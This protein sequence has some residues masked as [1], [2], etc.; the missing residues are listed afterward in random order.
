[1]NIDDQLSSN[2]FD[3]TQGPQKKLSDYLGQWIVLYFYP[4]D[5]TPGCTL[6]SQAFRD[7]HAEFL[8][9]NAVV[10]GVSR[11]SLTS[12]EKFKTKECLPFELIADTDEQLC[13]QFDVIKMKSM[14]GKSVRGIERST[15]LIDPEGI[16]RHEWRKVKVD[17]HVKEVLDTLHSLS[18]K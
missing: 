4:K 6:E 7:H 16:L 12:H 10:L 18:T 11:D 1:M 5:A 8:A 3:T 17:G 9:K 15:F 13:Q 14:Y 2:P